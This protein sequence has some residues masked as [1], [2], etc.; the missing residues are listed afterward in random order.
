MHSEPMEYIQLGRR[1]HHG[2]LRHRPAN[3]SLPREGSDAEQLV[4]DAYPSNN[5][6]A[7]ILSHGFGIHYC[8]FS[9]PQSGFGITIFVHFDRSRHL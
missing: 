5:R 4:R 9:G 3:F 1:F 7:E 2:N 8:L 6:P